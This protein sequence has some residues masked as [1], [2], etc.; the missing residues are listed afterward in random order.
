VTVLDKGVLHGVPEVVIV[1][2]DEDARARHARGMLRPPRARHIYP[3]PRVLKAFQY[4][5]AVGSFLPQ[6]PRIPGPKRRQ[7]PRYAHSS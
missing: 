3:S 6:G 4:R 2:G 5:R 7:S 1:L